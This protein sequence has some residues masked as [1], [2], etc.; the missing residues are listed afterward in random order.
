MSST[1]AKPNEATS[2][3]SPST[4]SSSPSTESA[5][6]MSST[7][8]H[9]QLADASDDAQVIEKVEQ[10]LSR[11]NLANDSYLV[12]KMKDDMYIPLEVLV[13]SPG[14]LAAFGGATIELERL[15]R[16]LAAS[17][18]VSLNADKTLIKPNFSLHR[19]T[20]ILRALP[21]TF[22]TEDIKKLL[23]SS[24]VGS[25]YS[26][27]RCDVGCWFISFESE[28]DA[29]TAVQDVRKQK[30]NGTNVAARLKSES[31]L[32]GT[33]SRAR[34]AAAATA[35]AP[36][37]NSN[38]DSSPSPSSQAGLAP[39]QG[40]KAGGLPYYSPYYGP[41]YGY[42]GAPAPHPE[43]HLAPHPSMAPYPQPGQQLSPSHPGAGI[44]GGAQVFEGGVHPGQHSQT[45]PRS[46]STRPHSHGGHSSSTGGGRSKGPGGASYGAVGAPHSGP[47]GSG[48]KPGSQGGAGAAKRRTGG[49]TSAPGG[50]SEGY[51]PSSSP[52]SGSGS[53]GAAGGQ[54]KGRAPRIGGPAGGRDGEYS[55]HP[56]HHSGSHSRAEHAPKREAVSLTAQN[57]PPLSGSASTEKVPGA[58]AP[59]ASTWTKEGITLVRAPPPQAAK[60][61]VVAVPKPAAAP[62]AAPVAAPTAPVVESTTTSAQQQPT[63]SPTPSPSPAVQTP[64]ATTPAAATPASAPASTPVSSTPAPASPAV[65]PVAATPSASPAP[66]PNASVAPVAAATGTAPTK[67]LWASIVAKKPTTVAQ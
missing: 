12:S 16:L 52:S 58:S 5:G 31:L 50:K 67:P 65:A 51:A 14:L 28:D 1:E 61:V 55:H 64:V 39:H 25:K 20:M 46:S 63:S 6:T 24:S 62:A 32:R 44:H 36:S 41:W 59:L 21:A 33:P 27:I 57:F 37:L 49:R 17:T 8:P 9:V 3:A 23:E 18:L 11:Q 19:H 45:S 22:T 66:A 60:P 7:F 2:S 38:T 26:Q 35:Q 4:S 48:S 42:P 34:S 29:L 43:S 47:R 13:S 15:K 53:Q 30:I 56:H 10:L 40:G 54:R